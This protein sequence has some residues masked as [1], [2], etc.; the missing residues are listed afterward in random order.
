MNQRQGPAESGAAT[1][2]LSTLLSKQADEDM[3]HFEFRKLVTNY[4][5]VHRGR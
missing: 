1:V 2:Y 5:Y 4:F 3:F